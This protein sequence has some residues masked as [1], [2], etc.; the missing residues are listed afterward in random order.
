MWNRH[1]H[2]CRYRIK[3]VEG[4]LCFLNCTNRKILFCLLRQ[5]FLLCGVK[6]CTLH[7]R[8]KDNF[9]L[10]IKWNFLQLFSKSYLNFT[11]TYTEKQKHWKT[12]RYS[13]HFFTCSKAM[14]KGLFEML[15]LFIST[16]TIALCLDFLDLV[17]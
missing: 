13:V 17:K 3:F 4:I 15:Y 2:L 10:L 12:W 14:G 7:R 5:V 6:L 9:C 16:V 8:V 11:N 1:Q